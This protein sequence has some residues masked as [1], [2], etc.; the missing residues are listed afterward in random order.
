M[1]FAK[2]ASFDEP[3]DVAVDVL[4]GG[5]S[6]STIEV[7]I[8]QD[9]RLRAAGM[10]MTD[11]GAEDLIRGVAEMPDVPGPYDSPSYDMSV[12]GRDLRI[13]DDGYRADPDRV[14]PQE[15]YVWC[16]FAETPTEQY[17]HQALLAQSTT[18]WT[19]A[20]SLRPHKGITERDAHR[21]ISTGI[22]NTAV[23]FHDDADVSDWLLYAN[24]AI[25]A[26][27]GSVQGEGRVFT[28]DGRLVASYSVQAI[29]RGFATDPSAMGKDYSDAM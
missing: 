25:Y 21:T 2:A 1:I 15:L 5:R 10:V 19:I 16:R 8:N 11:I 24:P 26:G 6:I 12:L 4:R 7:K 9:E 22:M 3:L 23:A 20:A 17:L 18:H 27:R 28:Q 13:V 14:G 29:V